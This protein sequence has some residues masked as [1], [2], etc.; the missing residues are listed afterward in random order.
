MKN[1]LSVE[2]ELVELLT[3]PARRRVVPS[4]SYRHL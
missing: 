3:A 4:H 2:A 1:A